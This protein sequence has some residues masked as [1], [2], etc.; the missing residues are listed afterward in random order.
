MTDFFHPPVGQVGVIFPKSA[1]E[2]QEESRL[3]VY[4]E[5]N[6]V[7]GTPHR[8]HF[9]SGCGRCVDFELVFDRVVSRSEIDTILPPVLDRR[10]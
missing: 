1:V 2:I 5:K 4:E 10:Q 3:K 9:C 6:T 7:S 8:R